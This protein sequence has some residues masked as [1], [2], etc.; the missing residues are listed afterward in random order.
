MFKD[1]IIQQV[2]DVRKQIE[3]EHPD[4]T[5][6]YEHYIQLQKNCRKQLVQRKP[7]KLSHVQAS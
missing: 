3:Q 5:S 2:R 4:S 1:P 7:K 6:F